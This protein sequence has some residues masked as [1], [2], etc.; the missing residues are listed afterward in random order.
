MATSLADIRARIAAQDNK[1]K[2]G[3]STQ[4]DNSIYPHWNADE[5]ST[6]TIRFLP[7]GNSSNTYF[8]VEKQ[9]IKLPFNGVKGDT[10][11]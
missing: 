3:T 11:Y 1:T 5:G 4:S 8:W 2:S 9:I 10:L 6:A 7:D